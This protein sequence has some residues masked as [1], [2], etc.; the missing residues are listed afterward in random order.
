MLPDGA[1]DIDEP[2]EN[3]S[4]PLK[5]YNEI[6]V[7]N[8]LISEGNRNGSDKYAKNG[9]SSIHIQ[10][11]VASASADVMAG[12]VKQNGRRVSLGSY[13]DTGVQS[14]NVCAVDLN[15][16]RKD[17]IAIYELYPDKIRIIF[18]E[19]TGSTSYKSFGSIDIGIDGLDGASVEAMATKGLMSMAAGDYDRDGEEELAFYVPGVS[20]CFAELRNG[21]TAK[22]DGWDMPLSKMREK[23]IH[24]EKWRRPI[25]G[26]STTSISG[27]D[28][29]VVNISMPLKDK[30]KY[31]NNDH[32]STMT[33]LSTGH[34]DDGAGAMSIVYNEQKLGFTPAEETG[35]DKRHSI[36]FA[37]AVDADLNGDK[38]DELLVGGFRTQD[39]NNSKHKAGKLDGSKNLILAFSWNKEK[40]KYEQVWKYPKEVPALKGKGL[41]YSYD[42]QEPEAFA[43][44]QMMMGEGPD[45]IFLEGVILQWSSTGD[46]ETLKNGQFIKEKDI[47]L[48]GSNHAFISSA[49]AAP[50]SKDLNDGEQIFFISGHEKKDDEDLVFYDIGYVGKGGESG[51]ET[52][53]IYDNYVDNRN[54]DDSGTYMSICPVDNDITDSVYYEYVGKELLWTKPELMAVVQPT[55]YWNESDSE[56][57]VW[58]SF[59][60]TK[61]SGS[62][63]SSNAGIGGHINVS[64]STGAGLFD[65]KVTM[66]FDASISAAMSYLYS[67]SEETSKTDTVT[68]IIKQGRDYGEYY[69]AVMGVPMVRYNYNMW[70]PEYKATEEY[71]EEYNKVAKEK[72]GDDAEPFGYKAGE[73]VPGQFED[74]SIDEYGQSTYGS[75][76]LS[77]YNEIAANSDGA[78]EVVSE[79]IY[80]QVTPGDPTTYPKSKKN[81]VAE[82]GENEDLHISESSVSVTNDD[83]SQ[84]RLAYGVTLGKNVSHGFNISAS[85]SVGASESISYDL[86]QAMEVSMSAGVDFSGGSGKRW[87][88]MESESIE[89]GPTFCEFSGF[90]DTYNFTTS[91]AVYKMASDGDKKN[92]YSGPYVLSYIVPA[93]KNKPPKLAENFVADSATTDSVTLTWENPDYRTPKSYRVYIKDSSYGK[94]AEAQEIGYVKVKG[95]DEPLTF[96]ATNLAPGTSYEFAI[97]SYGDAE[98]KKNPSCMSPWMKQSTRQEEEGYPRITKE[99]EDL[100]V[101]DAADANQRT[102]SV[103][104]EVTQEEGDELRFQWQKFDTLSFKWEDIDGAYESEYTVPEADLKEGSAGFYRVIVTHMYGSRPMSTTSMPASV[105]YLPKNTAANDGGEEVILVPE[106]KVTA[107]DEKDGKR[108]FDITVTGE[109]GVAAGS[110]TLIW[111][112]E[113]KTVDLDKKGRASI[114]VEGLEGQYQ[115]YYSGGKAGSGI[116]YL[117]A[118]TDSRG[119]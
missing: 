19:N 77:E 83:K 119:I 78:M 57:D 114:T 112:E 1:K 84:S 34:S 105:R 94:N 113:T 20:I 47:Y 26:L 21:K 117:P 95:K 54:E 64:M 43:A 108:T 3:Q 45:Q 58:V 12:M 92:Q 25:V 60:K 10:D 44:A 2:V 87:Y 107:G 33:I 63:K 29:L 31:K 11:V 15:G 39:F 41:Y 40:G 52:E 118:M 115:I 9:L 35:N 37:S 61:G 104:A 65:N 13:D 74:F 55:P 42:M 62:E 30:G 66:G 17:E 68:L 76:S 72:M 5:D 103:E 36:R 79:D 73:T 89:F 93:M 67:K 50:Y 14:R 23:G 111:G 86:V 91:L 53:I 75:L 56:S 24:F 109:K 110:I 4:H 38:V 97:V 7:H 49:Y 102:L 8:L 80:P 81:L 22:M 59:S 6:R 96:T 116:T 98:G 85:A 101:T 71:I 28:D 27:Y 46:K 18:E 99:P 70:R 32:L 51:I 106:M 82:I 88:N 69:T 90:P 16:D 100:E 48:E